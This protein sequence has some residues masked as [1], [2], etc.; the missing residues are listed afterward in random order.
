[1]GLKGTPG[2]WL[3]HLLSALAAVLLVIVA[4]AS[5]G[6]ALAAGPT[7]S[8][9]PNKELSSGDE[10]AVAGS[11][12][13]PKTRL[14]VMQTVALPRTGVPV[15]HSGRTL[16]TTDAKGRFTTAIKVRQSFAAIDCAKTDCFVT[17]VPINRT[18]LTRG[19]TTST[20]IAFEKQ[21]PKLVLSPAD[22]L[23]HGNEVTV[24]GTGFAKNSGLLVA[25]TLA[26]PD[27]G[28]PQTHLEP[29][30][31]TTDQAGSFTTTVKV[32]PKLRD[33]NCLQTECFIAAYP[34]A[35][36]PTD[37]VNDAW[38]A[39][40]FD[41][42]D[43]TALRVDEEKIEQAGTVRVHIS[44]GQPQDRYTIATE[45]AGDLSV[46]PFVRADD[47]GNATVLLMTPFDQVAG[48]YKVHLTNERTGNQTEIGFT[49]STNALLNPAQTQGSPIAGADQATGQVPAGL[50]GEPEHTGNWTTW[51]TIVGAIVTLVAIGFLGWFARDERSS[52]RK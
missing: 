17:A 19:Q 2:T 25:Q 31:V 49:I 30:A 13:K 29:V 37:R 21:K 27:N 50:D 15:V 48:D 46:Q 32:Q 20:P 43:N 42:S 4:G 52:A 35:Q 1:M 22:G 14:A 47:E 10:V 44:G 3:R 16:L 41:P 6:L 38:A 33:T 36:A 23:Q 39:I 28:R 45:G 8:V 51:W 26:R 24:T 40:A 11:G 18:A 9:T 7:L 5:G 34:A 12:F